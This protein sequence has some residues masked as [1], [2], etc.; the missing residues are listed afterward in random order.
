MA[1][2]ITKVNLSTDN[3]TAI[4]PTIASFTDQ[5]INAN[6]SKTYTKD[7]ALTSMPVTV[8][9]KDPDSSSRTYGKYINS[10]GVATIAYTSNSFTIYNDTDTNLYFNII[11]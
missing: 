4:M 9:V 7:D 11:Y 10:E 5:L 6:S 1:N 3:G 8:L 2:T